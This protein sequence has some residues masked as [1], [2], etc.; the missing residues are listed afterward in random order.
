MNNSA[1]DYHLVRIRRLEL[2]LMKAEA[3]IRE[4]ENALFAKESK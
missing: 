2:E 1:S 4:L 3:R